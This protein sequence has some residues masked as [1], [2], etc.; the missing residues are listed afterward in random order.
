MKKQKST[1]EN[2]EKQSQ[3]QVHNEN[4]SSEE[5]ASVP[6]QPEVSQDAVSSS[7]EKLTELN[8]KYVRLQAEFDNYRKRT[9]KERMDMMKTA[10]EDVLVGL[11]PVLDNVERAI[12]SIEGA[13]SME[14]VK[15]GVD[16]IF[17]ELQNYLKSKGVNEIPAQGVPFNTDLHHAVTKFP[18]TEED[19]KG[20]VFDV[21]RKGYTLHD[22]VIRFAEVVVGE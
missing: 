4:I 17:K 9:L 22:K 14:A 5:G 8:D 18:V 6:E 13:Q 16:I 7:E 1:L 20:K 15:E 10:G 12:K 19:K 11:L 3:D 2:E 21:V